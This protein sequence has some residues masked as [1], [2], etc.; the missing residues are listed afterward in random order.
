MKHVS[1]STFAL[2][3]LALLLATAWTPL[4]QTGEISVVGEVINGTGDGVA[5]ESLPVTLHL[6]S[7]MEEIETYTGA[8]SA[9][10]TF[11][12]DGLAP[13]AGDILVARVTYQDVTYSSEFATFEPGQQEIELPVTI[14]ETTDD[15]AAIQITQMHAFISEAGNLIQVDEYC[16]VGNMGDRTYVGVEDAET[17]QR[18]TLNFSLPDGAQDLR[19]DDVDAQDRFLERAGGF[20]DTEPIPP[21]NATVEVRYSYQLPYREGMLVER[22]FEAPVASVVML[23]SAEGLALEGAGVVS[24]GA[25]DT[26]MGTALSYTAG[27]LA[28]GEPLA[29]AVVAQSQTAM[30]PDSAASGSPSGP[31]NATREIS[32]GLVALAVAA[33]M[34][35]WIWQAPPPDSI[36]P[37]ARPLVEAIAALDADFEAG[38]VKA[39]AYHKKRGSFKQRL[40]AL[41]ADE[42]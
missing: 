31:R 30:P 7:E 28:A 4:P 9:G 2:T 39:G 5:P 17:G 1:R 22:V 35:F 16:M 8:L 6:F 3:L 27:P 34:I 18:V 38:R 25:M 29:F 26:Q 41:F 11:H 19:F 14:Y 21:G 13:Q 12:F 10:S 24:G 33:A 32:I 36:P 23:V 42:E 40:R 37:Q 15:P 20:G